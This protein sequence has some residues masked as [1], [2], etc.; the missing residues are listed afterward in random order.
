MAEPNND[1]P[2]VLVHESWEEAEVDVILSLLAA[3][4]I[5]TRINSET[6]SVFPL[7]VDGLGRVQIFVPET[8]ADEARALL[9][10][11]LDDGTGSAGDEE[12]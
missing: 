2:M 9:S 5:P 12:E 10:E 1:L 11:H 4:G 3:H 6:H 8:S 7:T